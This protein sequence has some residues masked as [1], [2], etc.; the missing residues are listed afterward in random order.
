MPN[1]GVDQDILDTQSNIAELEKVH[2]AW[3]P[4]QD[5]EGYWHVPTAAAGD[6]YS[7]KS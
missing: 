1:F 7:Y 5:E 4:V 2:G 6:S 3:N